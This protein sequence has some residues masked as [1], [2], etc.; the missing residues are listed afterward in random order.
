MEESEINR[1]NVLVV[2]DEEGY[3][4]QAEEFLTRQN[5]KISVDSAGSA[6]EALDLIDESQY[7]AIAS[8][9]KMPGK[10]GLGLLEEVREDGNEIPFIILTGK[11]KEEI[12]KEALNLDA[13]R[14]FQ[15]SGSPSTQFSILAEAIIQ[16]VEAHRAEQR[17]KFLDS[18]LSHDL[19][20]KTEIIYKNLEDLNEADFPK[21]VEQ[22]IETALNAAEDGMNLI[23]ETRD[24]KQTKGEK[25]VSNVVMKSMDRFLGYAYWSESQL[26]R[27]NLW[28]IYRKIDK[29]QDVI[30]EI[31]KGSAEHKSLLEEI[32]NNLKGIEL[33]G[34]E[35]PESIGKFDF[36]DKNADQIFSELL[37]REKFKR[38]VYKKL[39]SSTTTELVRQI[40]QGDD[41]EEYF[42]ILEKL[43]EG[44]NENIDM[45]KQ[46]EKREFLGLSGSKN[47]KF[48][49]L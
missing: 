6:E 15:K 3:R 25:K 8:D 1:I 9:Y 40:W 13:D 34:S 33:E 26:E 5:E 2:D 4:E 44:K 42:E 37:E 30:F 41:P 47:K 32:G 48:D 14:Y 11:G 29:Y 39:L 38:D 17:N 28:D 7:D 45:F 23:E 31:A 43:V 20:Q 19:R 18:L 24:A 22:K 12:A 36:E 49:Y 10:S 46:I 21:K 27:S 35:G 16:V